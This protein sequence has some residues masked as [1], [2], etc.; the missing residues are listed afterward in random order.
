[1]AEKIRYTRRDLKGP[2][3]FISTFGR[4]IAW[5]KENRLRVAAGAAAAV[6]LVV[7]V[8]GARAYIDWQENK[9]SREL[10]PLLSRAREFVM[11]P[12][13]ADPEKVAVLERSLLAFVGS[14][15]KARSTVYARYYLGSIGFHRGDFEAAVVQ[16]RAGIAMGTA[17]GIMEYLL[18][19]AVASSL[20][21]KG[22]F[23]S[24]AAAYREA[25]GFAQAEMKSQ[26]LLGEARSLALAGKKTE[27]VALYRKILAEN[28]DTKSRNLIEIQLARME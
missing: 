26:S 2:D 13:T 21:A 8:L 18:R 28:P 20:E 17:G 27:A 10:W 22:D 3:E 19:E 23:E 25:A 12:A 5:A 24:A 6:A 4:G 1:M 15:P 16:F 14:H 7:L 9:A 11:A